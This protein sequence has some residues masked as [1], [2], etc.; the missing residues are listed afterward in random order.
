MHL[1]KF[2]ILGLQSYI[3]FTLFIVILFISIYRKFIT[4]WLFRLGSLFFILYLAIPETEL[5]VSR[6]GLNGIVSSVLICIAFIAGYLL[7][8]KVYF[9]AS[10]KN[11]KLILEKNNWLILL[12]FLI[13]FAIKHLIVFVRASFML[14]FADW[15]IF[16]SLLLNFMIFSFVLTNLEKILW[17]ELSTNKKLFD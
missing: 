5:Y 4:P 12:L 1:F 13:N 9:K 11:N 3:A 7:S 17:N 16:I 6:I 14:G 15:F 2:L 8:Q 10:I